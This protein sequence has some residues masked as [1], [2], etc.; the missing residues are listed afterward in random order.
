MRY[1]PTHVLDPAIRTVRG[2]A[3]NPGDEVRFTSE[4]GRNAHLCTV[5]EEG[6]EPDPYCFY[7]VLKAGPDPID[8]KAQRLYRAIYPSVDF[9]W[10]C[11]DE[12]R[13]KKKWRELASQVE[14]I[15]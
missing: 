5:G 4:G 14:F 2:D 8:E 1:D 9:A 3:L 13:T 12:L 10:E 6:F 11:Q 15:E 7:D